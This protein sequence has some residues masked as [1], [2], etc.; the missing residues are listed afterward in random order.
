MAL[1]VSHRELVSW[2]QQAMLVNTTYFRARRQLYQRLVALVSEGSRAQDPV[3]IGVEEYVA[4]KL[5]LTS[6]NDGLNDNNRLAFERVLVDWCRVE[7]PGGEQPRGY[8]PRL[9]GG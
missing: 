5:F 7:Q 2:A 8:F 1:V 4:V 6:R 3:D 9:W